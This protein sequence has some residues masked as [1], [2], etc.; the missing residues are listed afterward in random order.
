[1]RASCHRRQSNYRSFWCRRSV[2]AFSNM[3]HLAV[4]VVRPGRG[5][6]EGR[7]S[8]LE[9]TVQKRGELYKSKRH[10]SQSCP[11]LGWL[12][13]GRHPPLLDTHALWLPCCRVSLPASRTAAVDERTVWWRHVFYDGG[14][15]RWLWVLIAVNAEEHSGVGGERCGSERGAGGRNGCGLDVS[16]KGHEG[17]KCGE[18]IAGDGGARRGGA[19]RGGGRRGGARREGVRRAGVHSFAVLVIINTREVVATEKSTFRMVPSCIL[20][21]NVCPDERPFVL[22]LVS[23]DDCRSPWQTNADSSGSCNPNE[24]R[25]R[26]PDVQRWGSARTS[27][28]RPTLTTRRHTACVRPR[29]SPPHLRV[30]E[31]PPPCP[32]I[33][34]VIHPPSA[35]EVGGRCR[36]KMASGVHVEKGIVKRFTGDQSTGS[37]CRPTCQAHRRCTGWLRPLRVLNGSGRAARATSTP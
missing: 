11:F 9:A 21:P 28:P 30:G 33:S 6:G 14:E 25:T 24:K 32:R 15:R 7:W 3:G 4:P 2:F 20:G 10:N 18:L 17:G 36:W 12:L 34:T 19:R 31:G 16:E 1:M 26:A 13:H 23:P 35:S 27:Q 8:G 22:P 29:I 5:Q 37:R